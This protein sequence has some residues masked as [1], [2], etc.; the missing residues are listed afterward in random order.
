MISVVAGF[1][2]CVGLIGIVAHVH[3]SGRPTTLGITA[4]APYLIATAWAGAVLLIATRQWIGS[5]L[6]VT[7][8]V[9]GLLLEAPLYVSTPPARNAHTLVVMTSNLRLGQADPR[10][11]VDAVRSHHVD[12]LM[13][14][15]LTSEEE[16]R[17]LGAGLARLLPHRFTSPSHIKDAS[18]TGLW[19]KYPLSIQ[20]EDARFRFAYLTG[21]ISVPGLR[22]KPT[23]V[24]LHVSGPVP[25]SLE[26]RMDIEKLPDALAELPKD[27][28]VIVGGDFNATYDTRQFRSLLT[29]GYADAA[30]QAGAGV[31]RTYPSDRWFPPL[32]AIDH[33]VS[34]GAVATSVR[35]LQIS[36]SDHRA[37]IAAVAIPIS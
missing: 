30:D 24:A 28:S 22:Q 5:G 10:A 36:G 32:L 19:T 26:W 3:A 12:V 34:R 17:L 2:T 6:A 27:A 16:R 33:V 21:R 18:G 37:L 14:Q 9:W 20:H 23:V 7:V 31:T 25:N 15:E 35:T 1:F 4:A 8:A 29:G 13:L 11:V